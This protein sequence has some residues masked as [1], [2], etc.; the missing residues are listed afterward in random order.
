MTVAEYGML[1]FLN[2]LLLSRTFIA[3]AAV[4]AAWCASSAILLR[5]TTRCSIARCI[6]VGVFLSIAAPL[7]LFF[8][9]F[10]CLAATNLIAAMWV[11]AR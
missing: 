8:C 1:L 7:L 11:T 2:D 3:I 5:F 9:L 6:A 10:F 4:G